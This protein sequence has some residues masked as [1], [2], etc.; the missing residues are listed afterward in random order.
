MNEYDSDFIS[1]SLLD[2]GFSPVDNPDSA[3]LILINTCTV[4][5]K[6]EQKAF[7]LLGRMSATKMRKPGV[8]LGVVGC[9]AQQYGAKLMKRFP[10]L[11]LVMGPRELGN[12]KEILKRISEGGEKVVAKQ[13]ELNS[14]PP[15]HCKGHLNGKVT[16]YVSIME[17]CNNF[18]SYCI[19]PYV[20]GREISRSP[21][22]IVYELK[23][24]LSKGIK[25]ITLL[26]QNVNSYMRQEVEFCFLAR[27]AK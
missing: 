17:G 20:R 15:I 6:P 7:S 4:R 14:R 1:H 21:D 16:G 23:N 9:L 8:I 13:L 11:D 18:C 19:V 25:E 12:I 24:L 22:D 2:L 5:A 26:G 3:D 27:G 10:Q